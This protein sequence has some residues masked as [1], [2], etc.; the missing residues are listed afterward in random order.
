MREC[1]FCGELIGGQDA[2]D[3]GE[4]CKAREARKANDD[5]SVGHSVGET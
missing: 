1:E 4:M 2:I 3:R 5:E